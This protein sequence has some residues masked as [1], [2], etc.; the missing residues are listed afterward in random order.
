VL[1]MCLS[2]LGATSLILNFGCS[3]A[4]SPQPLRLMCW[5]P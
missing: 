5:L 4:V 2:C 3:I 1:V